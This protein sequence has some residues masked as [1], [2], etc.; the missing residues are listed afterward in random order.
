M[1]EG[2]IFNCCMATAVAL[3]VNF[4][5]TFAFGACKYSHPDNYVVL[6]GCG[7]R[8]DMSGPCTAY[9]GTLTACSSFN[10]NGQTPYRCNNTCPSDK[11]TN[12]CCCIYY[13]AT[14]SGG[15]CLEMSTSANYPSTVTNYPSS[16][17]GYPYTDYPSSGSGYPVT[18]TTTTQTPTTTTESTTTETKTTE[19]MTMTPTMTQTPL[20]TTPER[21]TEL[22]TFSYSTDNVGG[23]ITTP[24]TTSPV[25]TSPATTTPIETITTCGSGMESSSYQCCEAYCRSMGGGGMNYDGSCCWCANMSAPSCATTTPVSTTPPETTPSLETTTTCEELLPEK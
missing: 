12:E 1:K 11:D 24:E 16:G 22:M 4:A 2:K 18:D 10:L 5:P 25:T 23:G 7:Y 20:T 13:G 17:S 8:S 21:S 15:R 19:T 9:K 3:A 14:W 6:R